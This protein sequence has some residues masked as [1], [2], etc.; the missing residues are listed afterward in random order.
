M[1]L[2]L[3][4]GLEARGQEQYLV[5]NIIP[6]ERYDSAFAQIQRLPPKTS[7]GQLSAGDAF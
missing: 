1:V 6:G 7:S 3:L 4:M 2:T 5:L